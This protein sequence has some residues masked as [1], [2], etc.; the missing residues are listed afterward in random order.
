[1]KTL[2]Y[3][4]TAFFFATQL[5]AQPQAIELRVL[6]GYHA[7]NKLK[8]DK[9]VNYLIF[10][11]QRDFERYFGKIKREDMP[12]FEFEHVIVMLTAPT[13]E[14]YFL[15]FQPKAMKAGYYIEVYCSV[16]YDKH[17]L[18]YFDHPIAI[19]ALPKYFAVT[20]INFYSDGKKKL[21]KSVNVRAK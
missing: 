14:Q 2:L 20:Q 9:G 17:E 1:M 11:K 3:I 19:A 18:T 7:N 16:K 13:K 15:S 21:L 8:L 12:N 4:L 5:Y 6:Q 10:S